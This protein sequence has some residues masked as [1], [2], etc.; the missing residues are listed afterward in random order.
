[1]LGELGH[2]LKT[3]ICCNLTQLIMFNETFNGFNHDPS[4]DLTRFNSD[5]P[6]YHFV[7]NRKG[8]KMET[9][10]KLK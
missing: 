3:D 6:I 5:P 9:Y 8:T 10:Q 2:D 4:I 1:M 7:A